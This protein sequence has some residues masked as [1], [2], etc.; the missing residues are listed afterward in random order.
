V[1]SIS[2]LVTRNLDGVFGENDPARRQAAR[3]AYFGRDAR[4]EDQVGDI[5]ANTRAIGR[6]YAGSPIRWSRNLP[7]TR[8]SPPPARCF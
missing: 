4:D 8:Q 5:D 7:R 6:S 2:T 3:S 1:S